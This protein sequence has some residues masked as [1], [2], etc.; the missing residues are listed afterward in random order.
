MT[1]KPHTSVI[2]IFVL[3]LSLSNFVHAEIKRIQAIIPNLQCSYGAQGIARRITMHGW[4]KNLI[5]KDT[6]K[7]LIEVKLA[8]NN[9]VSL[10]MIEET[11]QEAAEQSS[12]NYN[13]LKKL[14]AWG[15]IRHSKNGYFLHVSGSHDI[16][17]LLEENHK[18]PS[19][20]E[21]AFNSIKEFFTGTN[22]KM[23]RRIEHLC[24]ENCQVKLCATIHRHDDK[25]YGATKIIN[26][27]AQQ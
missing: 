4:F 13:G 11:I 19:F 15:T 23:H 16:I 22:E 20:F 10:S 9:A 18:H 12:Y 14:T 26:L 25:T 1:K 7:G 8:N 2:L 3:T 6:T 27:E 5:N 24:T 17:Y 21:W